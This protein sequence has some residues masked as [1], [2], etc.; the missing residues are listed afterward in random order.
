M[1]LR[2]QDNALTKLKQKFRH[3]RT[4]KSFVISRGNADPFRS[5]D[6]KPVIEIP[7]TLTISKMIIPKLTNTPGYT[8]SDYSTST[9]LFCVYVR[10]TS[11]GF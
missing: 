7:L 10:I 2:N 4:A 11:I 8:H 5:W 6:A 1:E 9:R 3:F